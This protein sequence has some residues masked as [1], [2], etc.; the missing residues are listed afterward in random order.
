MT[1]PKPPRGKYV[2]ERLGEPA[3]DEA[4]HFMVCLEC[5]ARFDMRDLGEAFAHLSPLHG[6]LN[7]ERKAAPRSAVPKGRRARRD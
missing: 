2:G 3:K 4:E 5:G 7:R 6:R 1:F